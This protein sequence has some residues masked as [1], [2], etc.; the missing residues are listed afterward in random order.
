MKTAYKASGNGAI[1]TDT[2]GFAPARPSKAATS[3]ACTA[4]LLADGNTGQANLLCKT[5]IM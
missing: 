2:R 4:L 3:W 1:T 5:L